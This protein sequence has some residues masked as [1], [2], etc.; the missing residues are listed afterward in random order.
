MDHENISTSIVNDMLMRVPGEFSGILP[1]SPSVVPFTFEGPAWRGL[2][3]TVQ[4]GNTVFDVGAS[5]GVF[6]V[7]IAHLVGI[8]GRVYAYEANP[9]L[10]PFARKLLAVNQLCERVVRE[11]VC[12]ADRSG[13]LVQFYVVPGL[14]SP[15]STRNPH[16]V[17]FHSDA[18]LVTL[19]ALALDDTGLCPDVIK[20]DVEGSEYLALKGAQRTLRDCRPKIVLETHANEID[21]IG[22]SLSD[23]CLLLTSLQYTFTDLSTGEPI[24]A[25]SFSEKYSDKIGYLLACHSE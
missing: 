3:S 21:G 9:L 18:A 5:Y 10:E 22:G 13:S 12:V 14:H 2:V 23:V 7:L 15:A 20:M 19:P 8:E 17:N 16:I 1:V 25:R 24:D 6:T 4:P 11:N